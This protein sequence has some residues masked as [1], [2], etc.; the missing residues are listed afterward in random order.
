MS[1]TTTTPTE[2]PSGSTPDAG[3][4]T[5]DVLNEV[6]KTLTALQDAQQTLI[7]GREKVVAHLSDPDAHGAETRANIDKALPKPKWDGTSLAFASADGSIAT[8]PVNLK[9]ERGAP[10]EKGDP[11]DKGDPGIPGAA[12]PRPDH[13][14]DGT[15]LKVQKPDGSWPE[16]GVDLKGAK[17]D[18]GDPGQDGAPGAPGPA[19]GPQG[20][21]GDPGPAPEHQ[22][23]GTALKFQNADG[24]WPE[25]G[26]DLKGEKGDKGDPGEPGTPGRD[27]VDGVTQ[28]AVNTAVAGHEAKANAHGID[29]PE[30]PFRAAV[31]SIAQAEGQKAASDAVADI[32]V[33]ST[34]PVFGIARLKIGGGAG[35]WFHCDKEG[36]PLSL[37]TSY[38][39]R[40]PVYGGIERVLVDGQVMNRVPKFYVKHDMPASGSLA[41]S[42]ITF[43]SPTRLDGYH[44]HPAFM[45]NGQEIPYYLLGCYKAS[46]DSTNTKCQSVHGV[47]PAVSKDFSTFKG[48]CAARNVNGVSGFMMQD[49]YQT[50][51]VKLLMLAEFATPDMQSVLGMGHVAGS[52][53][54]TVDSAANHTPWRGFYG[55]YGNVWEMVDGI[56]ADTNRRLE[57][58]RNDGTRAYVSTNLAMTVY[59]NSQGYTGWIT[60]MFSDVADGYDMGDVFIPKS[61]DPTET[62]GTYADNHYG[63]SPNGVCYSGG[64]WGYGSAAGVFLVHFANTASNL[65]AH[66]GC[67]LA[68][69]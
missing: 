67:R 64:D 5:A 46:M 58:Y 31:V 17:G 51:A 2:T 6:S 47:Y 54:V 44:V 37:K 34:D 40:H 14:W 4:N 42:K 56:R 38:F 18:K 68:K 16:A 19:G 61:G 15:S 9:G 41:G 23:D 63:A 21:K 8:A 57:I 29:K 52:G 10:G 24:S 43:I 25:R 22:W 32:I 60:E 1:D 7:E 55:L 35:L 20:E 11:G 33:G 26:V 36:E 62:N 39:D 66:I 49:I 53:A 12:G 45:N 65:S 27:G 50:D 30:S 69:V 28:E 3:A 48:L 13:Q 59:N